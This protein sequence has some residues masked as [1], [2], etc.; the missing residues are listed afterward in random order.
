MR[1]NQQKESTVP[2]AAHSTLSHDTAIFKK[3]I[4]SNYKPEQ[5]YKALD[6][7]NALCFSDDLIESMQRC[8]Q[9]AVT[10]LANAQQSNNISDKAGDEVFELF[11]LPYQMYYHLYKMHMEKKD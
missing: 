8:F 1:T 3:F 10:Y 6:E 9:G 4:L 2:G 7:S 5:I 11:F